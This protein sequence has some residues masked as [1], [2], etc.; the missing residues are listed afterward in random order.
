MF[1]LPMDF[2]SMPVGSLVSRL[3]RVYFETNC[4]FTWNGQVGIRMS[5]VPGI[6]VVDGVTV[7]NFNVGSMGGSDVVYTMPEAEARGLGYVFNLFGSDSP[8]LAA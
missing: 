5:A 4:D 7:R 6:K 1:A 2:D 8:P 3:H